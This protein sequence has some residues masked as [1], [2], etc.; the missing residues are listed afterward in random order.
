MKK[1]LTIVAATVFVAGLVV[2]ETSAN[3]GGFVSETTK[4]TS[5]IL[6]TDLSDANLGQ[7]V[8][9]AR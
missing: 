3:F 6:T 2:T 4:T 1:V 8:S 7:S 5:S 9:A